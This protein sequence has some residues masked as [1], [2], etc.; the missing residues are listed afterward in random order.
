[1]ARDTL[2]D[3]AAPADI[4]E[5]NERVADV[6]DDML[7]FGAGFSRVETFFKWFNFVSFVGRR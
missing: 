7:D 6:F 5:F 3:T 4:F 1:M 2:F